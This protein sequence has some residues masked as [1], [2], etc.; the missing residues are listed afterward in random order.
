MDKL[1]RHITHV[2]SC[3]LSESVR[4]C[5][6]GCLSPALRGVVV[7]LTVFPGCGLLRQQ[8]LPLPPP[9][10]SPPPPSQ[11]ASHHFCNAH[12]STHGP[13][14][15]LCARRS[16]C[17]R[18]GVHGTRTKCPCRRACQRPERCLCSTPHLSRAIKMTRCGVFSVDTSTTPQPSPSFVWLHAPTHASAAPDACR[19]SHALPFPLPRPPRAPRHLRPPTPPPLEAPCRS[20]GRRDRRGRA[21]G[22]VVDRYPTQPTVVLTPLQARLH[23]AHE[24]CFELKRTPLLATPQPV[25][26][27]AAP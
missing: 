6:C 8:T 19:V 15:G 20:P 23:A 10:S 7:A 11:A 12:D 25:P 22:Q 9:P 14:A 17:G 27:A 5:A 18:S 1:V 24:C 21:Q 16:P 4:V 2:G 26:R 3:G 13:A